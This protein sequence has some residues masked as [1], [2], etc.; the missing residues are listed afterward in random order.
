[1]HALALVQGLY[2]VVDMAA[3][4]S[5]VQPVVP[6]DLRERIDAALLGK[7]IESAATA[8]PRLAEAMRYAAMPGAGRL[9]PQLTKLVATAE[10][11]PEPDVSMGAAL[12]VELVHC[13]SLVHDD[14][15]CF[16]DAELRRGRL[17]V[18]RV[19]GEP[20]ALL[21][22]DA[23]IVLAFEVLATSSAGRSSTRALVTTLA[24]GIGPSRGIIAGQA[25]E[26][27][28]NPPL[29]AYHA[30]KTGALFGAAAAMGAIAAGAEP[31][32]WRR[33]GERLGAAYQAADDLA[34]VVGEASR[35]G[36]TVGRDAALD[37]PSVVRVHGVEGAKGRI[38]ELANEALGTLPAK[39]GANVIRDWV[40]SKV[41]ARLGVTRR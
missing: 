24:R 34:D 2:N 26:S 33:F 19:Y 39:P 37:R 36:K 25:W 14:L 13:A 28:P 29:E 7:V 1:M 8:P 30:A 21:T 32:T 27:E 11:D 18:H 15:P 17:A 40:E 10:G 35:L 38:L 12:A 6:F 9:R 31:E 20:L 23:F 3:R 4:A 22:G 16:D 5:L 41:L